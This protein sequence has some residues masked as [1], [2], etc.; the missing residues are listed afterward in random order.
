MSKK[1]WTQTTQEFAVK[2]ADRKELGL[3]DIVDMV[4]DLLAII[5]NLE[6]RP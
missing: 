2:W 1:V 3:E 4:S 5:K 6:A